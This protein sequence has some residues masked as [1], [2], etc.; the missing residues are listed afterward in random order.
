[1]TSPDPKPSSLQR[2]R[3]L[4]VVIAV[5]LL[6]GLGFYARQ[7]FSG[8]YR[9]ST[10]NA[11][12]G[13]YQIRV[14]AQVAGTVAAVHVEDTQRVAAGQLLVELDATDADI[15]LRKS[16]AELAQAVQQVRQWKS[17]AASSGSLAEA[18][19]A[20]MQQA[21]AEQG[22]REKLLFNRLVSGETVERART[23][24]LVSQSQ[25]LAS[26]QQ[27]AAD[28]AR[29]NHGPLGQQPAVLAARAAYLDAAVRLQR[30]RIYAPVAGVVAQRVAQIGSRVDEGQAI[31]QIIPTH[32]IWVD[33][34]FKESQLRNLRIGQPAVVTTDIYGSAIKYSGTVVGFSAGT[35]ATFALLPTQN[36]AGNWVKVVQRVPVR[37]AL[38][39]DDLAKHPLQLG[40]SSQVSVDT[41]DREM[42]APIAVTQP[43]QVSQ[44]SVRGADLKCIEAEADE[45]IARNGDPKMMSAR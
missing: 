19:A 10:D 42:H 17:L 28:L 22:R 20:E 8:Q 15:A 7:H 9:E 37:I 26:Q 25:L 14:T 16:A 18:R 1:M 38:A 11:Y 13:G 30:T 27:A 3:A 21:S 33:A 39:P 23:Q 5:S 6:I 44:Q 24:T 4:T 12:V 36:A 29:L 2:R 41:H 45:I 31:L 40:I 35:G 32:H 34:N 43:L